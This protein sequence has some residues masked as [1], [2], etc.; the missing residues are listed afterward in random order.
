MSRQIEKSISKVYQIINNINDRY[1]KRQCLNYYSQ[2]IDKSSDGTIARTTIEFEKAFLKFEGVNLRSMKL[3]DL[4]VLLDDTNEVMSIVYNA[5]AYFYLEDSC[6][7][8]K[9]N[10]SKFQLF[11]NRLDTSYVKKMIN[12]SSILDRTIYFIRKDSKQ[13]LKYVASKGNIYISALLTEYCNDKISTSLETSFLE[14]ISNYF[15]QMNII[16]I[17]DVISDTFLENIFVLNQDIDTVT[18]SELKLFFIWVINQ[19]TIEEQE[20]KCSMY[21]ISLLGKNWFYKEFRNNCR[22]VKY[23][24]FDNLPLIDNW[25]LIPNKEE[26]SK[27]TSV[28][29]TSVILLK[30]SE[31]INKQFRYFAKLYFWNS[32]VSLNTKSN[33]QYILIKFINFSF[34]SENTIYHKISSD[35]LAKFKSFVMSTIKNI[36]TRRSYTKI[37]R[38]F[39]NFLKEFNLIDVESGSNFFLNMRG[40]FNQNTATGVKDEDLIKLADYLSIHKHDDMQN[41]MNYVIFHICLNTEFRISQICSLEIDC[42][43]ESMKK[44]EYVIKSITKVSGGE[45]IEQ[46]CSNILKKIVDDYLIE[47]ANFRETLQRIELKKYL[48]VNNKYSKNICKVYTKDR[49]VEGLE[50]A[51]FELKINKITSKNLRVTYISNAYEYKIKNGLSD[52]IVLGVTGHRNINTI[53]N[54]YLQE[55]IQEALEATNNI[56]IGDIDLNGTIVIEK[57]RINTRKLVT[58]ESEC[59]FCQ[60]DYCKLTGPLS[61]LLCVHF[62]TTLDRVPFFEKQLIELDKSINDSKVRHDIEALVNIKRLYLKYLLELTKIK[63]NLPNEADEH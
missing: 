55:K 42:I 12:D 17:F 2:F 36:E 10:K 14:L 6:T 11:L 29:E 25:M 1:T 16:N 24:R 58:V 47:S 35:I 13:K 39:M 44:N 53:H 20:S 28:T 19:L 9:K 38:D 18:F 33:N 30:F 57:K 37:V 26:I 62:V 51:C 56:I 61:C 46:P 23:T 7:L 60:S 32:N 21:N 45:I 3:K 59:G 27:S 49:F 40:T 4:I 34:D 41:L 48:F 22:P 43:H 5:F 52:V 31:I 54:H 15:I 8:F 63:E 50:Y